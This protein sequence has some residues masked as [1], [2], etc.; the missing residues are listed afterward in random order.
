MNVVLIDKDRTYIAAMKKCADEMSAINSLVSF[1]NGNAALSYIHDNEVSVVLL[2]TE[3]GTESG[4]ELALKIHKLDDD[5]KLVFVTE[6]P[7]YGLETFQVGAIGYILKP[8]S[9]LV[10]K[11]VIDQISQLRSNKLKN[12]VFIQTFGGFDVFV[13][14]HIV[15][16][17]RKSA[18]EVLAILVDSRGSSLTTRE[19]A[20]IMWEDRPFDS[21]AKESMKKAIQTLKK[22]LVSHGVSDILIDNVTSRSV[23]ITKF[24]CD[25]YQFLAGEIIA[26]RQY[27]GNYMSCYTWAEETNAELYE[28]KYL[29]SL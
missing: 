15:H 6:H 8:I 3:I 28:Q 23:D 20:A 26:N 10:V 5:I 27:R 18:K 2:E 1:S 22:V 7:Q 29:K 21:N 16:F 24:R 19:I 4:I 14:G 25:F 11:K 9:E 12:R 17:P 13:D